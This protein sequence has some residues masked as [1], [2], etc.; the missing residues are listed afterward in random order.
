MSSKMWSKN[1]AEVLERVYDFAVLGGG[2]GTLNLGDLPTGFIVNNAEVEM[3]TAMTSAGSPT[4]VVGED[5]GGDDDGYF[6]T[7]YAAAAGAV[8]KPTG[9]LLTSATLKHKVAGTK[10]GCTVKIATAAVTAGKFVV[11]YT[12]HQSLF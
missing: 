12:G 8:L 11:R 3:I 10:D 7:V 9:A 4:V 1:Q 2:I 5:G 6:T